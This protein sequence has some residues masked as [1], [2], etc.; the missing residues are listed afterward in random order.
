MHLVYPRVRSGMK[1][2][3]RSQL[4]R[5]AKMENCNEPTLDIFATFRREGNPFDVRHRSSVQTA[6]DTVA[7]N[8]T[9]PSNEKNGTISNLYDLLASYCGPNVHTTGS[10]VV[11]KCFVN[12]LLKW[13]SRLLVVLQKL[14]PLRQDT[15]NVIFNI[16]DLYT[17][18]VFRLCS[19][20]APCER[21]LLG[22]DGPATI[23]ETAAA[24]W[25]AVPS[26]PTTSAMSKPLFGF[27]R[28]SSSGSVPNKGGGKSNN[29]T[30]TSPQQT[31]SS[32]AEAEV[33]SPVPKEMDKIQQLKDYLLQAQQNLHG[34]CKLDLVDGWIIDANPAPT[35]TRLSFAI[36][37]AHVLKKRQVAAWS[38]LFAAAAI[39][40]ATVLSTDGSDT[41]TARTADADAEGMVSGNDDENDGDETVQTKPAASTSAVNDDDDDDDDKDN[42]MGKDD[43]EDGQVDDVIRTSLETYM[44]SYVTC[45]PILFSISCQMACIRAMR[46][47]GVIQEVS[48]YFDS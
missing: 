12:G 16:F 48:L 3:Q 17:T 7:N 31:L 33:Y 28:R 19:G 36:K 25:E 6:E 29:S 40:Q 45:A 10:I 2:Y 38:C 9:N 39:H 44:T 14:P 35:D 41:S 27:R 5:F 47:R 42:N 22:I 46:G 15:S 1:K 11:P 4:N 24:A 26:R 43:K 23:I 18:T 37:A 20:S 32:N 8:S 21:L 30:G 13:T 34:I